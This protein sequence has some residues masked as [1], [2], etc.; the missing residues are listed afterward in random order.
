MVNL[1]TVYTENQWICSLV[2]NYLAQNIIVK[3]LPTPLVMSNIYLIDE[4]IYIPKNKLIKGRRLMQ[5]SNLSWKSLYLI[6]A[7]VGK[8]QYQV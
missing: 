1:D 4:I 2:N 7:M 5:A 6:M 8:S 3:L